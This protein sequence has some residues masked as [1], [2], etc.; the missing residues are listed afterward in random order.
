MARLALDSS[1]RLTRLID[2]I[3]DI[4]RIESGVLTFTLAGIRLAS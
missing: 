4:E 1:D 3:L 2:E